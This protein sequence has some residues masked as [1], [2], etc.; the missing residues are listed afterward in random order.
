MS[1][2]SSL[3]SRCL[4]ACTALVCRCAPPTSVIHRPS[5]PNGSGSAPAAYRAPASSRH[6]LS[7]NGSASARPEFLVHVERELSLNPIRGDHWEGVEHVPLAIDEGVR[8]VLV[9]ARRRE[10]RNASWHLL[11]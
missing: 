1:A 7:S 4:H 11:A 2:A 6:R 9:C 3:H 5:R 8:G 10:Q